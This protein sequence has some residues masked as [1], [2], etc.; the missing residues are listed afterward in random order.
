MTESDLDPLD[1]YVEWI[2]REVSRPVALSDGLRARIMDSVRATPLSAR[3]RRSLGWLTAPR[4]IARSPLVT[5][6]LAA[7]LVGIGVL[8]GLTLATGGRTSAGPASTDVAAAPPRAGSA[9]VV[10]HEFVLQAPSASAV[11]LVGDFN[12]WNETATPMTRT[13]NG[14]WVAK[15]HLPAGLHRYEFVVNGSTWTPDP[16]ALRAPDDGFG[17][18]SVVLVGTGSAT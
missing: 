10:V 16:A 9:P 5:S 18:N 14:T 8:A 13:A 17:A 2:V 11:S 15:I 1:P 4:P 12:N 6:L 3:P 7:G